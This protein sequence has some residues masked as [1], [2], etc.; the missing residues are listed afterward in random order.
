VFHR[1]RPFLSDR[2]PGPAN[3]ARA[4][5]AGRVVPIAGISRPTIAGATEWA[6]RQS[7]KRAADESS[8]D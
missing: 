2:R 8:A 5:N 6:Q 4:I 3:Q 1:E 7:G